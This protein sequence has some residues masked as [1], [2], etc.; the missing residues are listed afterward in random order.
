M[1]RNV[2]PFR[3]L[4][5]PVVTAQLCRCMKTLCVLHPN[6]GFLLSNPSVKSGRVSIQFIWLLFR[7]SVQF[8]FLLSESFGLK[9]V[10]T[11]AVPW[12]GALLQLP[13]H[14]YRWCRKRS[15]LRFLVMPECYQ[16]ESAEMW[17]KR[18]VSAQTPSGV[19]QPFLT[20]WGFQQLFARLFLVGWY[21]LQPPRCRAGW[22][23][24]RACL[25]P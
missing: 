25:S 10:V 17:L 11:G 14:G 13:E 19:L 12:P 2:H 1:I 23:D 8:L 4:C 7:V 21:L 22:Q 24:H 6:C 3:G 5:D 20:S 15:R 9:M 18:D 16:G